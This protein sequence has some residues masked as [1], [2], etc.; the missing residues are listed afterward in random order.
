MLRSL[1]W[2]LA[3]WLVGALGV[4]APLAVSASPAT[5]PNASNECFL[6][7]REMRIRCETLLRM[8]LIEKY[9]QDLHIPNPLA[10]GDVCAN[11]ARNRGEH[12]SCINDGDL[13]RLIP[14]VVGER[15]KLGDTL[16]LKDPSLPLWENHPGGPKWEDTPY[17]SRMLT[18]FCPR[19]GIKRLD[20]GDF[21]CV[22]DR[23]LK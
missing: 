22:S 11:R 2:G 9:C 17:G 6:D 1:M 13:D 15:C 10:I 18:R 19:S 20:L 3:P 7:Q 8:E 16:V 4:M 12:I 5:A 23:G 21:T 14:V